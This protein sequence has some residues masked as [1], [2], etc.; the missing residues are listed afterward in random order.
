MSYWSG[1]SLIRLGRQQ[2]A[3]SLF[4]RILEF[5]H[6][7][8]ARKAEIDYFATS[9]PAMLLFEE[10]LEQRQRITARFLRA[11][12]SFGLDRTAEGE[13]LLEQ[14]LEMDRSHAGA[15]DLLQGLR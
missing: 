4:H 10:D 8:E 12:A 13:A 11:Q 15:I 1:L 6:E 9:L 3:T 14:V 2:E 5:A 7:L